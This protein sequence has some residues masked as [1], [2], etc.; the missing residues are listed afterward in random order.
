MIDLAKP[1]YEDTPAAASRPEFTSLPANPADEPVVTIITPYYN[2]GLVFHETART[3]LRQ[4][5][6]AWEW[7]IINDGS[8]DPEAF[9]ALNSYLASVPLIRVIDHP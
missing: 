5:F 7:L 2:T 3:V 9:V 6:Q 1:N 8:T 4:T